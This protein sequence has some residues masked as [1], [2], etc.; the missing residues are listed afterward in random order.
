MSEDLNN[1]I[2]PKF[3]AIYQTEITLGFDNI[4]T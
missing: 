1:K 2:V 3:F 4:S